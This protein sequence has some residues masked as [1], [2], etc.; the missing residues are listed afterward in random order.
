MGSVA[1]GPFVARVN[2]EPLHAPGESLDRSTL[3]Q[4]ACSELLRQAAQRIGLLG[5]EDRAS[6]DGVLSAEA[7]SAFSES[8][9]R[10]RAW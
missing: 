3:R 2:G 5:L 8:R 7:S 1:A 4:R 9:S 10:R 6:A